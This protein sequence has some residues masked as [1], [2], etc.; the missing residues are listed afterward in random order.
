MTTQRLRRALETRAERLLTILLD[1]N[2]H[3]TREL[4]RRV[5]HTFAWARWF[6]VTHDK[7]MIAKRKH[8]TR[9][10]EYEYRLVPPDEARLLRRARPPRSL[11]VASRFMHRSF[12]SVAS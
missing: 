3:A 9:I 11:P 6:L 10:F 7:H 4:V 2:W 1:G 5:G 12:A 8:A